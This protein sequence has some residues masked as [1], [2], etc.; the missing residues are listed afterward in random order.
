MSAPTAQQHCPTCQAPVAPGSAFCTRCGGALAAVTVIAPVVDDGQQWGGRRR[1]RRSA[2]GAGH[3]AAAGEAARGAVATQPGTQGYGYGAGGAPQGYGAQGYGTQGYGAVAG[4]QDPFSALGPQTGGFVPGPPAPPGSH[5]APGQTGASA[6]AYVPAPGAPAPAHHISLGPAFDGVTPAGAGRRVGAYA[7]DALAVGIVSGAVLGLT[8][9]P[10]YAA[11]AAGELAAGLVVWEAR[12]GRTI[13]NAVLGLRTAK[14]ETPYAPGLGRAVG[15]AL[16]LGA[17]HLVLGVGQWFL[18]ASGAF[19]ATGRRQ[20]WHDKAAR[21]VVVDV[22]ALRITDVAPPEFVPPVVVSAP[23][24][25]AVAPETY[26]GPGAYA[27]PEAYAAPGAYAGPAVPV[28]ALVGPPQSLPPAPPSPGPAGP[29]G[30]AAPV[31]PV[32]Q[33]L[34][35][36]PAAP[37]ASAPA[38]GAATSYVVTLDTGVAMTVSGTGYVGRRPQA[39]EGEVVDHVI[40]IDDPG[41]SLSRTHA[42]FGLD[43][44]GFWVEDNGSANGTFVL[45]ADGSSLQGVPGERLTVPEGGTVRLGERTFTVHPIR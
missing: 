35:V 11:L 14:L 37:V 24:V 7:L 21:T 19:D 38:L 22:R 3:G 15:R 20:G 26:A 4:A 23:D 31:E 9:S 32:A 10:V 18:V 34:P 16:L 36:A 17:S 25:V 44:G 8:Q 28:G 2:R 42:R 5:H 41:R 33:P 40:E 13:G 29:V 1:D 30:P 6:G 27:E 12:S 45:G 43:A 39:P